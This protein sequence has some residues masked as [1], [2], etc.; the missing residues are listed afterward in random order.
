MRIKE[1]QNITGKRYSTRQKQLELIQGMAQQ[2]T[3]RTGVYGKVVVEEREHHVMFQ[4]ENEHY[5]KI[6]ES[7]TDKEEL[8]Y[9]KG[10]VF[11]AFHEAENIHYRLTC[12]GMELT[13]QQ[14]LE[15]NHTFDELSHQGE[16]TYREVLEQMKGIDLELRWRIEQLLEIHSYV[17]KKTFEYAYAQHIINIRKPNRLIAE[18][19]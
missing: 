10:A 11:M 14:I 9:I 6:S 18:R 1:L 15:A 13:E 16:L 2:A 8:D 12:T 5:G 7:F 19:A 17:H 4:F 3:V